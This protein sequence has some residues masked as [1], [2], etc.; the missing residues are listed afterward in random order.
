MSYGDK[1]IMLE[2]INNIK[3][4]PKKSKLKV[5]LLTITTLVLV[6]GVS[7]AGNNEWMNGQKKVE[8][9]TKINTSIE[10]IVRIEPKYPIRAAR[11]EIEGAVL[12]KFDI[13]LDGSPKNISVLT[14]IPENVFNRESIRALKQWKYAPD[15][16]KVLKDNVVQ[17]DFRMNANSTFESVNLIE[18]ISINNQKN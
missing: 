18:K 12:L 2:S 4:T 7:V 9:S 10:P 14:A 17:L 8:F 11:D 1:N 3:L 15:P 5:V 6:T 16:K 13:D